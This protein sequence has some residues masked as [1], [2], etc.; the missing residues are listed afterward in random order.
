M[1]K[2]SWSRKPGSGRLGAEMARSGSSGHRRSSLASLLGVLALMMVSACDDPRPLV[3]IYHEPVRFD[4]RSGDFSANVTGELSPDVE[5]A[6]FRLNEG[7]WHVVPQGGHRAP[8]PE[9]IIEMAADELRP[10]RNRLDL[11]ANSWRRQTAARSFDFEYV[12]EVRL[13]RVQD[14]STPLVVSDGV[15]DRLRDDRGRWVVH[16][17]VGH[18][19]YD[20]IIIA[21]GAFAGGRRVE[22]DVV[23]RRTTA[24]TY[25]EWGFGLLTLWGGHSDLP[26][27][28]P[29]RGWLFGLAWYF[30]RYRGLGNEFSSR[31]GDN[32]I[33]FTST[34]TD[35]TLEAGRR[36]R[37]VSETR[38]E[39]NAA[40]EFLGWHQQFKWWPDG[41]PEPEGWLELRDVPGAPLP[42]REYGVA[43]VAYRA[44]V[45]FG[46][47]SVTALSPKIRRDDCDGP[48]SVAHAP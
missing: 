40:G 16:P 39:Q 23:W 34:A 36:Y 12:P 5:R 32:P 6:M 13:P 33:K 9:F 8:P 35:F 45:E 31:F 30:S 2:N 11:R 24:G 10:G 22:T 17:A 46:P 4:R 44:Q 28:A 21:C 47:V 3:T 27:V 15:W 42:N 38:P 26:N 29:K 43:F 7:E 18:E 20:R 37:I 1:L 25:D 19:G 48:A 14:W 41:E